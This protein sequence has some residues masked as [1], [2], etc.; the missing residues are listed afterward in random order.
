MA[1]DCQEPRPRDKGLRG[2]SPSPFRSRSKERGVRFLESVE[3]EDRGD[4]DQF[5]G[6]FEADLQVNGKVVHFSVDT[7]A[8]VTV[9]SEEICNYLG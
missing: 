5:S 2:R 8:D 4:T 9:L 1:R 7:G 3:R 6:D